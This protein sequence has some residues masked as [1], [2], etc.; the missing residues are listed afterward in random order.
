M[1]KTSGFSNFFFSGDANDSNVQFDIKANFID[2]MTNDS[3]IP[4][5]ICSWQPDEC[6]N[7]TTLVY[8][9][10][11]TGICKVFFSFFKTVNQLEIVRL[12]S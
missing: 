5:F 11:V 2:L 4:P 8:A 1:L 6:N 9:G 12:T 10:I 3:L 7:E